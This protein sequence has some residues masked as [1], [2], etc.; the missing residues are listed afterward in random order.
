MVRSEYLALSIAL[1]KALLAAP[2]SRGTA[3]ARIDDSLDQHYQDPIGIAVFA[4]LQF[5][6]EKPDWEV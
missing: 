3:F 5:A 6:L 4:G 1:G 2:G